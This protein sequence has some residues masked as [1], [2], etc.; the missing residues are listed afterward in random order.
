MEHNLNMTHAS[1]FRLG[2]TRDCL[3][4]DGDRANFDERAL[5]VLEGLKWEF[6]PQFAEQITPDDVA[7]YDAIMSLR[8]AL[9]AASL[10]GSE[11]RLRLL[12]RFGAGFDNVDLA[13][14]D[15]AGL[16]VT[17]APD[18]V[19]RPVATTILT[20]ILAL[21]HKLMIK[22]RLTRTG[23]WA[24]RTR[25]M[26]EGLVGKVVGSI[27]F[28][29]IAQEAFRLLAPLDM[30]H[31]AYSPSRHP[32]EAAALKVR[33]VEL[34]TLLGE[35]DFVCINAPL[36]PSSR[37]MIGARELGL[38][39]P[40]AYL[41]NTGRGQIIDEPAL[42]AALAEGRIAGAALDVFEQEPVAPDNPILALENVIVSPHSLCWTDECYRGIAESAFRSVVAIASGRRP[43]NLVNPAA[44]K[45]PRWT[46]QISA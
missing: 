1:E 43:V 20:F 27:G 5:A 11:H 44:L 9:T 38:M 36:T 6:L 3:T 23:R 28:G 45:H 26:G 35:A 24:E 8:P 40:T 21:S 4:P 39:K 42:Y 7:R 14:A 10:A 2:I 13:A 34:D 25:F 37:R 41:I 19:R 12:A 18:G 46:G 16:L 22:D 33:E 15:R 32:A 29:S 17:N 31:L 30:V